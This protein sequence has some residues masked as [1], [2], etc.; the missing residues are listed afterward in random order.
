M[1]HY[2]NNNIRVGGAPYAA[3][4]IKESLAIGV[5]PQKFARPLE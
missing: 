5:Y 2:L 3:T 1:Q 4:L